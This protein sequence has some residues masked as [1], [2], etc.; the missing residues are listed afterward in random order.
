M[1]VRARYYTDPACPWSWS[2]EPAVRK[3]MVEFG[4]RVSWTY[5]MGGLARDYT[6][7]REALDA[8]LAHWL[9]IADRGEMPIDPRLWRDSAIGSSYPACMAVKAAAEQ[10]AEAGGRYLRTVRE[11]L[12]CFRRKLD[13]TEALVEEARRAGLDVERFRLDL[14]SNAIVEAFGNDLDETRSAPEGAVTTS[15]SGPERIAF[16]SVLFEGGH[17]AWEFRSYEELRAAAVA[18]G[19]EPLGEPPPGVLEALGRFGTMATAEVAAVCALPG[20]RAPAELWR[21]ASE[22]QVRPVRVVTGELWERA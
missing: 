19:A 12:M 3:L 15:S 6:N 17:G 20:P 5:V 11:G 8:R 14:A 18:A 21:L 10:G 16:P 1:T 4:D 13:T 2:A 7:T 22:W 9:D